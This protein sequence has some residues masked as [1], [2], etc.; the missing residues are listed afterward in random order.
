MSTCRQPL[1]QPLNG[2]R[3]DCIEDTARLALMLFAWANFCYL[4]NLLALFA[5]FTFVLI[6]IWNKQNTCSQ[7]RGR[8]W[9]FHCLL[10]VVES[11]V[12]ISCSK[13]WPLLFQFCWL[14][15]T[16]NKFIQPQITNL[17]TRFW[18]S[19]TIIIL[20]NIA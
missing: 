19:S 16:K 17:T 15:I 4:L 10:T 14:F 11:Q 5:Q 8:P 6:I 7:N 20:N 2:Q 9:S 1:I 12:S 3:L 13:I 18:L